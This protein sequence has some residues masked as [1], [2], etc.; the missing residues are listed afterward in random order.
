MRDPRYDILFEPVKIGPVTARNR[1]YQVPHCDGLGHAF[2]K[3]EAAMRGIKAEG[4]WAVVSTQ[5]VEIHPSGDFSP[6][7]EGRLWDEGDMKRMA[8]MVEAVH[9]HDSLAAIEIT[10]N[11]HASSN[12]HSRMPVMA[13]SEMIIDGYAPDQTYAMT[14][15]D[16]ANFR[17][18]HRQ[19]AIRSRD[20]GFD[21]VYVYAAHDLSLPFHFISR[22]RN[23]RSDEYGGS[24]EN[25]VRLLKE[26]LEDTKEAV[27]DTCGIALRF[28]VDELIGERGIVSDTEGREV[29][30]MLADYPDIWDV[31]ISG[32]A[33]DSQTSRFSEEGFQEEYTAF[34]KQVTNKPVV[35]VGRFTSPDTMVSQIKR[36]VLDMIGA[37][38]PSIADPFLPEKI[39]QGRVEDIRECIGCNIC[40][41]GDLTITPI[42]CTQNPTQAEEFRRNWHPEE[43][44][45]ST[46]SDSILV[47]G[48]GPS[49]LEAAMSLGRRGY[50][51][52][53][54]DAAENPGGRVS[55][56]SRLPGLSAWKRVVDYRMGQIEKL[57]NVEVFQQSELDKAQVLEFARELDVQH[58]L[59]ATGSAW[60]R[61]GL[62]RQHNSP[63]ETDGSVR[64]ITPDDVMSGETVSGAVTVY[65]DD[66]FYM[67]GVIAEALVKMGVQVTLVTPAADVSTWTHNTLEQGFIERRL[68][69][70]GIDIIEKHRLKALEN[71]QVT[72]E[73]IAS[74]KSRSLET[75]N[76]AM[77]TAR[78]PRHD[79]YFELEGDPD[80]L[81]EAG[82]KSVSRIGDCLAPS[83]IATAVY[84]G[85]LY[86]RDF[87][88]D[89][90]IDQVPYL[91]ER[92]EI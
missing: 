83:T 5:E 25:R 90:D 40:V 89:I 39:S 87:D 63:V 55:R 27:G 8:L 15:K 78:R 17:R 11:G 50:T 53:V 57:D 47:I 14:R 6:F 36:G 44:E 1:F 74:G 10:H 66:H 46:S 24:L 30:E 65:D 52:T 91:R 9:E 69:E 16:I 84:A 80:A 81:K 21:I 32:W 76:L 73:H 72:I 49:G 26:V 51:V 68:H 85:H 88:C 23:T 86:A 82:I 3:A 56:E 70:L 29:V 43:I 79:L 54:A 33:N 58:V 12:N 38:R 41:S 61:D 48:A 31:N 92:M 20:I 64:V 19:A 35:G 7:N 34:V 59:C 37:A 75:G 28:A 60:D 45:D 42:R 4:G 22:N 18:W 77:V 67:G 13:V 62:G 71:G 2:P